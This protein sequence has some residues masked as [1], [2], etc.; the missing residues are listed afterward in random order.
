MSAKG[1]GGGF[2]VGAVLAK[3]AVAKA[4]QPGTHGT[5]YGGNPLAMACANA[6]LDVVLAEGFLQQV[7]DVVRLL[8]PL[9]VGTA[10]IDEAVGVLESVAQSYSVRA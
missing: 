4:F 1:L 8:P 2:P 7:C 5:T 3:A 9:I 10:E 6:V